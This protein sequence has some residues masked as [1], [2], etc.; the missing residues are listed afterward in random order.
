MGIAFNMYPFFGWPWDTETI[1]DVSYTRYDQSML[2]TLINTYR[3]HWE[4]NAIE[5]DN[6]GSFR[7][8]CVKTLNRNKVCAIPTEVEK[9]DNWMENLPNE[10]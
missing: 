2:T 9:L 8:T 3:D 10:G 4:P 7:C 6:I 5:F 1:N